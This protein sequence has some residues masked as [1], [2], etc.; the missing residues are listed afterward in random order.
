MTAG[1]VLERTR[2][3][4]ARRRRWAVVPRLAL[5]LGAAVFLGRSGL[6]EL[7]AVLV[8][9]GVVL[10]L[11]PGLRGRVDTGMAARW[12]DRRSHGVAWRT[13][14]SLDDAD[15]HR[16]RVARD[17]LREDPGGWPA[18][19]ERRSTVALGLA[20]ACAFTPLPST[21]LPGTDG[22]ATAPGP[23]PVVREDG[24]GVVVDAHDPVDPTTEEAGTQDIEVATP[25]PG[26]D[27]VPSGDAGPAS[28][29]PASDPAALADARDAT[30]ADAPA[31]ATGVDAS[32]TAPPDPAGGPGAGRRTARAGAGLE[33]PDLEPLPP[34]RR[35]MGGASSETDD[36]AVRPT[37]VRAAAPT[38]A[39][40]DAWARE[41]SAS[42]FD[43]E[44]LR[45]LRAV[46]ARWI[47]KGDHD[48]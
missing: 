9:A 45:F 47:P 39:G 14:C 43:T 6:G 41:A 25:T 24:S 10:I 13:W 26:G 46:R 30:G 19:W 7:L 29:V 2:R 36:V 20:A 37:E 8:G 48:G 21:S 5:G 27:A 22:G 32:D 33:I 4:L 1:E 3:R 34:S 40:V 35:W 42:W 12:R 28:G 16:A 38:A 17:A 18:R 11:W 23:V 31:S 15:P 44:E